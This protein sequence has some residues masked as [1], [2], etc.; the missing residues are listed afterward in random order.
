MAFSKMCTPLFIFLV[1]Y[2]SCLDFKYVPKRR[3]CTLSAV[4]ET[5]SNEEDCIEHCFQ[6]KLIGNVDCNMF[7]KEGSTCRLAHLQ[8]ELW[9]KVKKSTLSSG[10]EVRLLTYWEET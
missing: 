7:Y 9:A 8:N 5:P 6:A 3:L 10:Q 1:K 2:H 4:M